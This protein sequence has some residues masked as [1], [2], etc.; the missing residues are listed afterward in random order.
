MN[1]DILFCGVEVEGFKGMFLVEKFDFVDV[2]VVVIVMSVGEI[3]RVFVGY[4]G[5]E[6]IENGVGGDVFGG[7]EDDGFVLMLDFV[8]L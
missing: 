6:G 3:F 5:V 4:G 8:F 2:L 7:D 1:V